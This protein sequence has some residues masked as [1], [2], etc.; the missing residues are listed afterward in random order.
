M[1][2]LNEAIVVVAVAVVFFFGRNHVFAWMKSIG[3]AK[4]AYK[5]GVEST[6]NS[7]QTK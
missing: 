4:G 5:E 3:K 2:G 1:I 6:K 7:K